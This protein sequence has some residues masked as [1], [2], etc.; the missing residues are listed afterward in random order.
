MGSR[1]APRLRQLGLASYAG[2][3][4]RISGGDE[5]EAQVMVDCLTTNETY[6]FREP[7]HFAFIRDHLDQVSPPGQTLRAWSAA[8]SSG[9]EAY[10]LA[11][12]LAHER[13]FSGWEILGTDISRRVLEAAGRGLYSMERTQNIPNNY[14]KQFCLKGKGVQQGRMLIDRRLRATI[15][16]RHVNLNQALPDIGSFR[17]VML[18]NVLIYFDRATKAEV[19]ARVVDRLDPGGILIIGQAETLHGLQCGL[20]MLQPSIYEK[21]RS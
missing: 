20:R 15:S 18:R 11:M 17:L 1:L 9:E 16:F 10:S 2:Y 14:L 3:I 8:S 21:S 6:F 7:K 13:G 4:D 19:V 5:E 12:L